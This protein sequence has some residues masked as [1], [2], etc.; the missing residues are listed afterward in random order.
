MFFPERD[1][2]SLNMMNASFTGEDTLCG[3]GL[4][5]STGK[6]ALRGRGGGG[7]MTSCSSWLFAGALGAAFGAKQ[8][9]SWRPARREGKVPLTPAGSGAP[10]HQAGDIQP[11]F[12]CV[13]FVAQR[14]RA[15]LEKS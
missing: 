15:R 13:L 8:A 5:I 7:G 1:N 10:R 4:C 14:F 11:V 12:F 2:P 6:H 9:S 3:K